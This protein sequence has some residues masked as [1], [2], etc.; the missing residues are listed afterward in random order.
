MGS[1]PNA[2]ILACAPSNSAADRI[3]E[4][5]SV[6]LSPQD[7]FRCNAAFRAQNTLKPPSLIDYCFLQ[8]NHFALPTLS[9]LESYKVIVSTC[10]NASFPYNI[11]MNIGHFTYIIVDEAGQA[12]EPEVLTAIKAIV[13]DETRVILAGDPKQLGP[14]IRSS[15]ARE[16]GLDKSYME[17]LM[18]QSVYDAQTAR[19]RS[20]VDL[21]LATISK[22][23]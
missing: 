3:A 8:N 11:G 1:Q 5:L 6:A 23:H 20:C 17:R 10:G 15:I 22:F 9:R 21:C 13:G 16:L 18:E 14:V 19:G 7:M 2:K 4:L 12:T